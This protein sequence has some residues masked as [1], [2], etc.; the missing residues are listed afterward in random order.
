MLRPAAVRQRQ[1]TYSD[2]YRARLV[3]QPSAEAVRLAARAE[4]LRQQRA[5]LRAEREA[6]EESED[7][8]G[9]EAPAGPP[10]AALTTPSGPPAADVPARRRRKKRSAEE[11]AAESAAEFLG[12]AEL[13]TP[14]ADAQAEPAGATPLTTEIALLPRLRER[15][16]QPD[17]PAT[18]S[19]RTVQRIVSKLADQFGA[20]LEKECALRRADADAIR[21]GLLS[22]LAVRSRLESES[23]VDTAIVDNIVAALERLSGC[24]DAASTTLLRSL[25]ACCVSE[26]QDASLAAIARRLVVHRQPLSAALERRS[27]LDEN[28]WDSPL[29]EPARYGGARSTLSE[30]EQRVRISAQ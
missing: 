9:A 27:V 29:A 1:V 13:A 24:R 19:E 3:A 22:R 17:A 7:C 20:E 11:Q 10:D 5:R 21:S 12:V 15:V 4:V 14:A 16:S 8:G 6:R 30:A 26:T 18:V 23:T 25:L 28:G 2:A